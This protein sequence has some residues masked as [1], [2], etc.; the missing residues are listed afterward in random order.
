MSQACSH[1]SNAP[2]QAGELEQRVR[3]AMAR[4]KHKLLV[5]SGKG[6]VGKSTVAV[7]LAVALAG[8][9]RAVG[10]LDVDL[11]G[12][13]IPAM[14]GMNGQRPDSDG[15]KV[16]P[17][18]HGKNLKVLSMGNFLPSVDD[19]V[20]WRGPMKISAIRQL[21]GDADWG[22][23][24]YLVIDSPPGTGDEPLTVAQ[25][26][27]GV[28]AIVVTTPQ[29]VSLA[30]VRKSITFCRQVGMPVVGVIENMSGFVCPGCGRVE[31]LFGTGGGERMASQSGVPFLGKIP[32]D[33]LVVASGELGQPL[34]EESPGSPASAAYQAITERIEKTLT[35][36][37]NG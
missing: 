25:E 23:L 12:P 28:Q 18:V 8:R 27:P 26:V 9:G 13:S 20:I 4:V 34:V 11:H 17:L 31:N 2:T 15:R 3:E 16:S 7:N 33:P 6:G 22:A 24:D 36:P 21:L 19:A 1:D 30:D 5:M 37:L 14:L 32:I 29:E 35:Q 10:L